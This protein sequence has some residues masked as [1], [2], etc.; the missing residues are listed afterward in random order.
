M[1][2]DIVV[3]QTDL[4]KLKRQCCVKIKHLFPLKIFSDAYATNITN[5]EEN[6]SF[7]SPGLNVGVRFFFCK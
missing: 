3:W 4:K 2:A 7:K 1:T 6:K 5:E